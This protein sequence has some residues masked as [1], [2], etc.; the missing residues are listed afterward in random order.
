[1]FVLVFWFVPYYDGNWNIISLTFYGILAIRLLLQLYQ[2][3]KQAHRE[4]A[5]EVEYTEVKSEVKSKVEVLDAIE[6]VPC[7]DVEVI[8]EKKVISLSRR[9]RS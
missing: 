6:V 1:M 2:K 5:D 8:Q 3:L 9:E 7:I 4:H